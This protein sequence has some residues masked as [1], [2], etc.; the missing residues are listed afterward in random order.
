M[1]S[2]CIAQ[3]LLC[4][5]GL[6]LAAIVL[7]R[8]GRSS[9]GWRRWVMYAIGSLYCRLCFRWRANG[10]CPF[11]RDAPAILIVNHRGPV[12][13]ILVWPGVRSRRPLGFL[14][15]QEYYHKPGLHF[16][17]VHMESIP[18]QRSGRDMAATRAAL[19]RLQEGKLLGIFPEGRINTGPGLLPFNP[20]VGW[21]ALKADVPV[22]PVFLC[23][24]PVGHSMVSAFFSFRPVQVR[25]GE[26]VDL[27]HLR[28]RGLSEELVAEATLTLRQALAKLGGLDLPENP[29]AIPK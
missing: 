15:A 19:R 12:D 9:A 4:G 7:W 2:D 3:A 5:Y 20:G 10:P 8:A 14:T 18:T 25:Y 29:G 11:D 28:N 23:N 24:A 26:P 21:L 22:Y 13:P 1:S 6:L 17:C 27:S 16:I